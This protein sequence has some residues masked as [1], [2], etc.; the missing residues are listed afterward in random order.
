MKN[1]KLEIIK[2]PDYI[3]FKYFIRGVTLVA[4]IGGLYFAYRQDKT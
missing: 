1:E 3:D 4:A 2:I